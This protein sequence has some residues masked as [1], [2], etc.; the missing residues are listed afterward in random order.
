M[1]EQA[2][3]ILWLAGNMALDF[4]HRTS[5]VGGFAEVDGYS[6]VKTAKARVDA[7]RQAVGAAGPLPLDLS[8]CVRLSLPLVV[9]ARARVR[10]PESNPGFVECAGFDLPSSIKHVDDAPAALL[11]RCLEV[12]GGAIGAERAGKSH[13]AESRQA[14]LVKRLLKTWR[15][16]S[17]I[18][19]KWNELCREME[20]AIAPSGSGSVLGLGLPDAAAVRAMDRPALAALRN[21]VRELIRH[22]WGSVH[23]KGQTF[24]HTPATFMAGVHA[25]WCRLRGDDKEEDNEQDP[26]DAA[27]SRPDAEGFLTQMPDP[28]QCSLERAANKQ[29]PLIAGT[30]GCMQLAGGTWEEEIRDGNPVAHPFHARFVT[31]APNDEPV[32]S[33]QG[34]FAAARKAAAA[35]VRAAQDDLPRDTLG[36]EPIE[37]DASG[38]AGAGQN[39]Q[40]NDDGVQDLTEEVD[41]SQIPGLRWHR[42]PARPA[43]GRDLIEQH[44]LLEALEQHTTAEHGASIMLTEEAWKACGINDLHPRDYIQVGEYFYTPASMHWCGRFRCAAWGCA[45][46][47]SR[48]VESTARAF[49]GV[50]DGLDLKT[51]ADMVQGTA[52]PR[53]WTVQSCV[54]DTVYALEAQVGDVCVSATT[55]AVHGVHMDGVYR[56][57]PGEAVAAADGWTKMF[58]FKRGGTWDAGDKSRLHIVAKQH[59]NA[60]LFAIRGQV[61]Q[62]RTPRDLASGVSASA[63]VEDVRRWRAD[64]PGKSVVALPGMVALQCHSHA[65]QPEPRLIA[66]LR[67]QTVPCDMPL[68]YMGG[69]VPATAME[70]AQAEE[71]RGPVAEY[72]AQH[73]FDAWRDFLEERNRSSRGGDGPEALESDVLAYLR[74]SAGASRR[75]SKLLVLIADLGVASHFETG[76]GE[77]KIGPIIFA[78]ALLHWMFAFCDEMADK[79]FEALDLRACLVEALNASSKS[80]EK[81]FLVSS[82]KLVKFVD[83]Y[84]KIACG[85]LVH[86]WLRFL[87]QDAGGAGDEDA[88]GAAGHSS[89]A[90]AASS[91]DTATSPCMFVPAR[92]SRAVMQRFII[93]LERHDWSE[94]GNRRL[95]VILEF[96]W[97]SVLCAGVMIGKGNGAFSM[98]MGNATELF[99]T[100]FLSDA[101]PWKQAEAI[102]TL[103][104]QCLLSERAFLIILLR[105]IIMKWRDGGGLGEDAP[106]DAPAASYMEGDGIHEL[107]IKLV[108]EYQPANP[109]D[110]ALIASMIATDVKEASAVA[111][112]LRATKYHHRYLR[113]LPAFAASVYAVVQW[114][115]ENQEKHQADEL[116]TRALHASTEMGMLRLVHRAHQRRGGYK[117]IPRREAQDWETKP[118]TL[119]S[120]KAMADHADRSPNIRTCHKA[121]PPCF[122]IGCA[123]RCCSGT[124]FNRSEQ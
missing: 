59:G 28:V 52:Q 1:R 30:L 112:E 2:V 60:W 14:G 73:Q 65:R 62:S 78:P 80:C 96:A 108:K 104:Q 99:Q 113:Q 94:P 37:P 31:S 63:A 55:P 93:W 57:L 91:C 98:A 87:E 53:N 122:D 6:P 7:L 18:D 33:V 101:H 25:R 68:G 35:R 118:Q 13:G 105:A 121:K 117:P 115:H 44:P 51:M 3:D 85:H 34:S 92:L 100:L 11:E 24:G 56:P 26:E 45:C 29:E 110:I 102:S 106:F 86:V 47:R 58:E 120:L 82:R 79:H 40:E 22:V 10:A 76:V 17:K 83:T 124:A 38:S 46:A 84:Y 32:K 81:V 4:K 69:A 90:R 67:Q 103:W 20:I 111:Q 72:V 88:T 9:C 8:V 119:A 41:C 66:S 27:E 15:G 54:R 123:K 50:Y 77:G 74:A 70:G 71:G 97:D 36:S 49:C 109:A 39:G 61:G 95:W 89:A 75:P 64:A 19:D 116:P 114:L 23:A 5:V 107:F 48:R 21:R 43:A 16:A 42:L 12:Y